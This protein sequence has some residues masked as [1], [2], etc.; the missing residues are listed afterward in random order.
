MEFLKWIGGFVQQ[1]VTTNTA[2]EV[3]SSVADIHFDHKRARGVACLVTAI[4]GMGGGAA[5]FVL[6]PS[7]LNYF[8]SIILK[9]FPFLGTVAPTVFTGI[10][11]AWFGGGFGHNVAKECAREYSERNLGHSNAALTFTD[12]DIARIIDENPQIYNYNLDLEQGNN[13]DIN[14]QKLTDISNL[15]KALKMLRDQVDQHKGDGTTAHDENKYA[16]MS[17]LRLSN[18]LP[19]IELFYK[20]ETKREVRKKVAVTTGNYLVNQDIRAYFGE[21]PVVPR[22]ARPPR[23]RNARRAA[24][25]QAAPPAVDGAQVVQAMPVEAV[26]VGQARAPAQAPVQEMNYQRAAAV[27]PLLDPNIAIY[28]NLSRHIHALNEGE[29]KDV[30][31]VKRQVEINNRVHALDNYEK[32]QFLESLKN[33]YQEQAEKQNIGRQKANP[34]LERVFPRAR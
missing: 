24:A 21:P 30:R 34:T 3:A 28:E 11:G 27:E 25:Q 8:N 4:I 31:R 1:T 18:L 33:T 17:A 10:I 19:M 29:V 6:E 13:A 15:K 26:P 23:G 5:L 20:S 32:R 7:I 22:Q 9:G 2:V 16:L 12:A 14:I